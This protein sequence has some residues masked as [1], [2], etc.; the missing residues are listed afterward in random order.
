[1]RLTREIYRVPAAFPDAECDWIARDLGFVGRT[2]KFHAS[3]QRIAAML[4]ALATSKAWQER[5]A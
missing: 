1:M 5:L 2:A 3:I 4:C